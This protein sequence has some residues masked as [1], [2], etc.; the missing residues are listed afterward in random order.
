M[1]ELIKK[2]YEQIIY[3]EKEGIEMDKRVI[4]E[5]DKLIIPY[6]GQLKETEL[7][8]IKNL[9]YATAL[10]AEQEG[11]QLGVKYATKM[12]ILLLFD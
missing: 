1:N 12:L 3:H 11:F 5:I 10:T 4:S 6:I 7:E 8:E 2:I 9:M